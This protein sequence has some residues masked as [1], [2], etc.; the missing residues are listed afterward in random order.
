MLNIKIADIMTTHP[1]VFSRKNKSYIYDTGRV[2]D[3]KPIEGHEGWLDVVNR[4]LNKVG[5]I[6]R[7]LLEYLQ[8]MG[9]VFTPSFLIEEIEDAV[10]LV[11]TQGR[12]FFANKRY[13]DV[14][15]V[16]IRRI[17]G[18]N[19]HKIEPGAQIINVLKNQKPYYHPKTHIKSVDKYVAL[20]IKPFYVDGEFCGAY[21]IFRDVTEINKL[22]EEVERVKN[23][24]EEYS[25]QMQALKVIEDMDI[26]GYSPNFVR[27]V[28]KAITVANTKA[29][30]LIRGE[31]GVG[32]EVIAR[33]IYENSPRKDK[34]YIV[35]N[36]AAIPESLIESELF[37]YEDGAFTGA[38][39]GGKAGK[40]ELADGGTLF[41]DEIGDMPFSMQAKLLRVL[42]NNEIEKIGSEDSRPIDVRII[43]A[44]NQP[45]EE[46]IEKREFRKDLY[47]RLNV[48][49]IDIPPL[50]KRA[51][52]AI[53]LANHFLDDFNRKYGKN[54]RISKD[55]YKL[56]LD[57]DWPGNVR[58]LKNFIEHGVILAD[59]D[60]ITGEDI[61][62]TRDYGENII[63]SRGIISHKQVDLDKDSGSLKDRLA[64]YEKEIISQLL[65]EYDMDELAHILSISKRTLYRK[66]NLYEI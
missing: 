18:R 16:E 44:T 38:K 57:H 49:S 11:D 40:F 1:R 33:L 25:K 46:M 34:P 6:H 5:E 58:E 21:S 31:Q 51:H 42:E 23:V 53:H 27:M 55:I 3:Y 62:S 12:I 30:I 36:C 65:Q 45:L 4:D 48:V 32:K 19:I 22:A 13:T 61:P 35:I 20:K 66:I 37:G 41:L 10:I 39:E 24:A 52:D 15:G 43:A 9:Q 14:L 26:I 47:Y 2:S 54:I 64:N 7:E 59:G 17:I 60:Q 29:T 56:I 8:A 63:P 50:R 28:D